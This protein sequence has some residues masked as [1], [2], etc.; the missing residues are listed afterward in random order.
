M[1]KIPSQA[2]YIPP[3][4]IPDILLR[5]HHM[6]EAGHLTLGGFGASFETEFAKYIGVKDAVAVNSGSAALEIILL[7]RG[8]GGHVL[9]PTNT[10]FATAAAVIRAGATAV[11]VEIDPMDLAPSLEQL[12]AARTPETEAVIMVH[13]GGMIS[14]EM[15]AI[16]Q[17]CDQQNLT[18]IEDAAHAH[19]SSLNGKKAGTFGHA[20]AFSF[21]P[22]KVMTSGEGG[23]ILAEDGD[24]LERARRYRDQGKI[25]FNSNRHTFLGSNWRMPEFSAI[26]GLSQLKRLDEFIEQRTGVARVYDNFLKSI[27]RLLA[28]EPSEE[29]RSNYY[30]YVAI[31]P[32]TLSRDEAKRQLRENFGVI[33]SG[34]VYELPLHK[35]PGLYEGGRL[36][37]SG[38]YPM[39]E[40]FCKHHVC[41]PMTNT[42][43]QAEA[44]VVVDVLAE[45]YGRNP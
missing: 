44:L 39:A 2:V 17:W 42:M 3:E 32:P 22:T 26:L 19:G 31:T 43:T 18:L 38:P 12:K 11:L 8:I 29:C 5:T 41:L 15:P 27:T 37:A 30:K 1:D 34:E 6:L 14:P 25:S 40:S 28:I 33:L 23:M 7:A 36:I 20:A 13:I 35:Q 9:V 10:F 45:V 4:D 16:R 21:Y 24:L